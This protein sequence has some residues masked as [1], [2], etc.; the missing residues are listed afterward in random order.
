MNKLMISGHAVRDPELKYA[1][2]KGTP[3]TRFTLAVERKMK[4][5]EGKREADFIPCVSFKSVAEYIANYAVKGSFLEIVGHMQS[6]SY[7]NQEGKKVYTLHCIVEEVKIIGSKKEGQAEQ[8]TGQENT[9][10]PVED[11]EDIPF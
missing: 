2:G 11:D 5:A 10:I 6:G 8:P 1:P 9:F 3:V 4:N 7:T